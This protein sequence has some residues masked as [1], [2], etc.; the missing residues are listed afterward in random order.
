MPATLRIALRFLTA[1]GRAMAM[2]LTGVACGVAFFVLTQAQ[3]A[4]FERFF[5]ETILGT[6]GALRVEDRVQDT[7]VKIAVTAEGG[8][9][10]GEYEAE[11][12][13]YVSGIEH[14]ARV[15]QALREFPEVTGVSV[16]LQG[17]AM[18][19]SRTSTDSVR[20]F[21]IAL[22]DHL[23][24]SAL[25][26]QIVTGDLAT[27][28]QSPTGVLVGSVLA[29]RLGVAVGDTLLL[30]SAG[31]VRRYQVS[32]VFETGVGEIDRA[33][34]LLHL[35]EARSLLKR[36]TGASFVQVSLRDPAQAPAQAAQ[37]MRALVHTVSPWQVRERTWLEVFRALRYSSAVTVSTI[38]IISGVGM[39]NT[40]AM[41]VIEKTREIA[42][43][44]S[45][46][47]TRADILAV[48]LWLGGL[49]L[50]A[51]AILGCLGGALA[52]W[53][54]SNLPLRIRG[55]FST[56]SFVVAW[57]VWH[58]VAAVGT[59]AVVV[60]AASLIPARRAARLEPGDVIRGNAP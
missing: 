21:G 39:F 9:P 8:G 2:S 4:G 29:G 3:T 16:V 44:R 50:V 12:R 19:R 49:V 30:E 10:A 41:L 56:N 38:I 35:P 36:P 54:V 34:L 31:Q 52:T 42:I 53:G 32:A 17:G 43:L 6:D 18:A 26:R 55:I 40:L 23:A 15:V 24:V 28:R 1:R 5:I 13:R 11:S 60:T 14:P 46:G 47:Y 58:Y 7:S 27:F 25:G 37:M 22:D 45:M 51:G 33:R 48:F 20:V 57:S 59:A